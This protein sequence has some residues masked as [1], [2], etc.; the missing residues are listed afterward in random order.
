MASP[1]Q[2]EY[3][4]KVIFGPFEYNDLTAE[5]RKHGLLVRLRGQPL[6]I[7]RLL[8]NA[9]AAADARQKSAK[10]L[11]DSSPLERGSIVTREELQRKLWEGSTLVDFEHGLNAAVNRLRQA[12]NDSAEQPRY[13]ETIPG[14]GYRFI[15]PVEFVS[16]PLRHEIPPLTADVPTNPADAA[17]SPPRNRPTQKT[18]IIV[19]VVVCLLAGGGIWMRHLVERQKEVYGLE[20][21]GEVY[22]AK[23]TE[24]DVRK[25]IDFYNR[26]I[27]LDSRSASAYAGLA[28]GWSFLS[29]LHSP[30]HEAME[31][32]KAAALR[33]IEL[34]DSLP[35]AHVG[36]GVVKL[37]YD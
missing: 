28:A 37:Q 18:L 29:D 23:W 31:R 34:N 3:S 19:A 36:L 17:P 7:L 26:A 2:L 15:A 12:L 10:E 1:R 22:V 33:A 6:Q 27:A 11:A 21:Q 30:P 20:M 9:T 13:I 14:R 35:S 4:D 32:S 5:L 16:R 8:L 25:G 24:A